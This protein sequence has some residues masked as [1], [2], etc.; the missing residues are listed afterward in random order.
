MDG[1]R[2]RG[3]LGSAARWACRKGRIVSLLHVVDGVP[4]EVDSTRSSK[5]GKFGL[6]GSPL[7][8]GDEYFVGVGRKTITKFR[9]GKRPKRTTCGQ[10]KSDRFTPL[11]P[12]N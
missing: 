7:I 1:R 9:I 3:T 10:A 8:A 11:A 4:V 5:R 6:E 2:L 12:I